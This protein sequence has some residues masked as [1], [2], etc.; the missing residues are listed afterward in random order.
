MSYYAEH[1]RDE[2]GTGIYN[3]YARNCGMVAQDILKMGG[4]DFAAGSGEGKNI[5]EREAL[6]QIY[7]SLK[8]LLIVPIIEIL[9]KALIKDYMDQT[10]PNAAYEKGEFE[11]EWLMFLTGWKTGK[12]EGCDKGE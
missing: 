9:I 11:T 12:V 5:D 6:A 4:K 2:N 8:R 1:L 10:M 3:L 7:S